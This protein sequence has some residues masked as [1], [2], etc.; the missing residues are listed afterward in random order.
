MRAEPRSYTQV[1]PNLVLGAPVL[2]ARPSSVMAVSAVLWCDQGYYEAV[3]LWERP[4][5]KVCHRD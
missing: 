4:K 5:A 2:H 1:L 3:C